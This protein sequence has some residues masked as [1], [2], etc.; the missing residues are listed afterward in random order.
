MRFHLL[1]ALFFCCFC[2]IPFAPPAVADAPRPY[3]IVDTGQ[4][5]CYDTN[6]EIPAPLPGQPF[7][8]QDAQ[9]AGLLPAYRDNNDDTVSDLN[10]GLIWVKA[11]GEK[12]PW[13]AA[14]TGAKD[15]RVGGHSDWRLPT[16]KELYSLI[17][18]SGKCGRTQA[19]SRPFLDTRYFD[20]QYGDTAQG[21]RLIDCQDWAATA[22]VAPSHDGKV[23]GVNFADGRIKGYP[24]RNPR[25]GILSLYVRYVRGNP[26]YGQN[27]LVDSGD[28]TILDRATG[29]AWSKQ[30]SG[31]GC[32]WPAALALVARM[33]NEK[34][35]GHTDWRL[36]NAKELQSIVDYTRAPDATQ[37]PAINPLFVCTTINNEGGAPDYPFYW[38]GTT[39]LDEGPRGGSHAAVYVAFGRALGFMEIPPGAGRRQLIDVHGA[40]AQRSDPKVGDAKQF[41]TGRGPQGDVIRIQNYVRL[42][43]DAATK[44]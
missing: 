21:V 37:S 36:P 22:Y 16:I 11:R 20:F 33:N 10:T 19:E 28:G 12:M 6:G 31:T 9:H 15:C 34:Y 23:F 25:N 2:A 17:Q 8:G 38:T 5:I 39:H 27:D 24:R 35:L 7:Y 13:D 14:A 1:P 43:R 26:K 3:P 40:G 29:L 41:P 30:D 32:D 44:S 4:S 18:F 42:V